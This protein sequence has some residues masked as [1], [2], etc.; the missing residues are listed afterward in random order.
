MP[1]ALAAVGHEGAGDSGAGPMWQSHPCEATATYKAYLVLHVTKREKQKTKQSK[2]V[3]VN[4]MRVAEA[5]CPTAESCID[6]TVAS[7]PNQMRPDVCV[8]LSL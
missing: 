7:F 5:D 2:S 1:C 8:S 6:E 4:L 3:L